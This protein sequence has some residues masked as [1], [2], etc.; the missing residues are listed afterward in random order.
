MESQEREPLPGAGSTGPAFYPLLRL[1]GH[2][3][4]HLFLRKIVVRLDH[5]IPEDGPL[6]FASNHPNGLLD[7]LAVGYV[8]RRPVH[9]LA[10]SSLLAL[11]GVGWFLRRCGVLPVYRRMD[12]PA[13]MS[14]NERTFEACHRLLAARG[15]IGIFPEGLSHVAPELKKLMTGA[16][17][18]ALEAEEKNGFRLGVRIVPIGLTFPERSRFRSVLGIHVG[19]PIDL[20]PFHER[21]RREPQ[22]AVR[23]VT[24]LLHDRL[25]SH[26]FHLDHVERSTLVAA[27][28]SVYRED[29]AA[30]LQRSGRVSGRPVDPFAVER[31]I[32]RAVDYFHVRE[33]E[34]VRRL[35]EHVFGY[36][37][38]LR[39]LRLRDQ[40]LRDFRGQVSW[41]GWL[42][43]ALAVGL[44]GLPLALFGVINN[45]IPWFLARRLGA[46]IASTPQMLAQCKIYVGALVFPLF[47]AAQ[48]Y[49]CGRLLGIGAAIVYGIS[50]PVLGLYAVGFWRKARAAWGRFYMGY[51]A[52]RRPSLAARLRKERGRLLEHLHGLRERYF[53]E[54]KE[55]APEA[56]AVP[57]ENLP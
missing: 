52:L 49:G 5:P 22:E 41:A 28:T 39:R 30:D 26:M 56:G 34:T 17:R 25:K 27:L 6:V 19:E 38:R 16:A 23:E 40:A 53:L 48:I 14:K 10:R 21:Y 15:A 9:F 35:Q 47:Y 50:L 1:L 36:Q 24:A 54:T 55:T 13:E 46:R 32:A 12:N 33:P 7:P 31:G 57:R 11:P 37:A 45:L 4:L 44:V 2:G 8:T 29:L 43:R 42:V 51:L 18:I 3:V 20:A